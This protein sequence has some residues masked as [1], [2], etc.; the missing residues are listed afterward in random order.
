MLSILKENK[1]YFILF[2]I[3]II[4]SSSIVYNLPQGTELEILS[5]HNTPFF[6]VFFTYWTQLAEGYV[7]VILFLIFLFYRYG[8]A[9]YIMA[10]GAA[11]SICSYCSKEYF[12]CLRPFTLYSKFG[13]ESRL[14]VVDIHNINIGHSSF[15]SGHT[16]SAFAL[17]GT[18]AFLSKQKYWTN[19]SFFLLALSLGF[20]RM[21]LSQHFLRDVIGGSLVGTYLAMMC[22]YFYEIEKNKGKK[23]CQKKISF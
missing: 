11:V 14:H 19:I 2:F 15:P 17:F 23:W 6:D 16:M 3:F 10:L 12:L 18:L 21:Y 1:Y 20:S 13:V 7:Y 22:Y 9:V 8:L 4:A 5:K